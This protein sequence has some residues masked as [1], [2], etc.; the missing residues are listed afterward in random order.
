MSKDSA[1]FSSYFILYYNHYPLTLSHSKND[2]NAFITEG[3]TIAQLILDF[4]LA[5]LT[6]PWADG[7]DLR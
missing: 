2:I 6:K 7:Y 3:L 5:C 4:L 1:E